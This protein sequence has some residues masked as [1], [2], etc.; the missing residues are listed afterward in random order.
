[1]AAS[2]GEDAGE[3]EGLSASGE[4]DGSIV[5]SGDDALG[6]PMA[7]EATSGGVSA[8]AGEASGEGE[9]TM[10]STTSGEAAT[11]GLAISVARRSAASCV[12]TTGATVTTC[13]FGC[14]EER[15]S[16]RAR[17]RLASNAPA[18]T[19]A[20][21]RFKRCLTIRARPATGGDVRDAAAIASCARSFFCRWSFYAQKRCVCSGGVISQLDIPLCIPMLAAN[22]SARTYERS[23]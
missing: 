5:A 21:V 19:M 15:V 4:A 18:A 8:A 1:V 6:V 11:T 12:S 22:C 10:M 23:L 3:A 9:P 20:F 14:D 16:S 13:S 17:K 2:A 7:G